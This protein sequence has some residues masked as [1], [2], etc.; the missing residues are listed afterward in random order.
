MAHGAIR[1]DLGILKVE[2]VQFGK[3][4]YKVGNTFLRRKLNVKSYFYVI[5]IL[6]L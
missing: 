5:I 4:C 2:S 1:H 3:V 6:P